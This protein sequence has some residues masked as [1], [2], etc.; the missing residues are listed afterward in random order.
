MAITQCF[1]CGGRSFALV[2]KAPIG[3]PGEVMFIQC[4]DCGGVVGVQEEHAHHEKKNHER[5]VRK[6]DSVQ[7]SIHARNGYPMDIH[8][9]LKRLYG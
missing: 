8:S 7:S 4:S 3:Y 9:V 1:R 2:M 5:I 6:Q